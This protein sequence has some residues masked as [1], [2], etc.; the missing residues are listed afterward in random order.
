MAGRP[1]TRAKLAREAMARGDKGS[2]ALPGHMMESG[3][4][5][6][7]VASAPTRPGWREP[8]ASA[9]K[10]TYEQAW[11]AD[12][13]VEK[14][15]ADAGELDLDRHADDLQELLGLSL[16]AAK[17]IMKMELDPLD[18]HYPKLLSTQQSIMSSVFSTAARVSDQSLR[19]RE[20]DK[21]EELLR[22]LRG[23]EPLITK[24]GV[25]IRTLM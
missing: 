22:E 20:T 12:P 19:R 10:L 2:T 14:A 3:I 13:V 16:K 9:P 15:A 23:E 5:A 24:D 25:D 11:G 1:K 21:M 7:K 4:V 8:V 6:P 17:V 18:K